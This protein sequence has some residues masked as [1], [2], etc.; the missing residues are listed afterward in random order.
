M[1]DEVLERG[2]RLDGRKFDEIRADHDRSRRPAA[3]ARLGACSRAARRR[4]S[5]PR[6]SAPP[7]TQQKIETRRRRDVEALHAPL[8]LPAVLGRRSAVPARPGPPRDRPRRARRAR[9]RADDARRREVPLHHPRRLRHP[10]VE[11]LVVDGVGLRR[12]ARADGRRRAAQ[13]AGRRRRDGPRH[14]RED[15]QVRDPLATSPAPRITT[16]TWTSRSPARADGI[17]ALQMDIKVARHHDRDHA[18]GARAGAPAAGCTS[19]TRCRRRSP[20]PRANVSTLRAAHR[21]DPDPGRQDPRR[22]R[23]GRQD[24]PQHHRADRRQDRRR[25]RRPRERRVGRRGVGAEGDRR[26]SRS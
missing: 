13:G 6:R 14:G 7:T 17:T 5:S 26:S 16:A 11:R 4:R 15:R 18:Q 21:H 12:L 9:A 24:D 2:K 10:R 3:H 8:Q 25:G 20:A 22:H 23:T 1:R 19:S